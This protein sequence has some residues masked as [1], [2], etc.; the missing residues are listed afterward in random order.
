[1]PVDKSVFV[2]L[3]SAKLVSTAFSIGGDVD[4]SRL[5]ADGFL[6]FFNVVRFSYCFWPYTHIHTHTHVVQGPLLRNICFGE[7][8][9]RLFL[10]V[11]TWGHK[12]LT[13][14]K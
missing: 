7:S 13:T 12:F 9:K 5:C 4:D 8:P 6:R 10:A 1:M 3:G 2:L 11:K 14:Y